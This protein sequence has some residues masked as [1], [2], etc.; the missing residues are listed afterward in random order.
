MRQ[1]APDLGLGRRGGEQELLRLH[2]RQE[3]AHPGLVR[4]VARQAGDLDVM[5]GQHHGGAGAFGREPLALGGDYADGKARPSEVQGHQGAQKARALNRV[6]RFARETALVIDRLGG[7]A[8]GGQN[9]VGDVG[10]RLRK[11][12]RR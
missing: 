11:E 2:A 9:A 4:G 12:L 3:V 7:G 8:R 1:R 6:D 5:H 10:P